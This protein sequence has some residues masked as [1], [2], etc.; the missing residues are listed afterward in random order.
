MTGLS[1]FG[2]LYLYGMHGV[3][4]EVVFW[5]VWM[6]VATGDTALH[7]CSHV[8][9]FLIY[10]VF[11]WM[12]DLLS[13]QLEVYPMVLRGGLYMILIYVWEFVTGKILK[14]TFGCPWDYSEYSTYHVDGLVNF[15]YAPFWLIGSLLA[16]KYLIKNV[17]KLVW[18]DRDQ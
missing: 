1:T 13:D 4:V 12:I 5:A 9:A 2:R 18:I 3:V 14:V 6:L 16:E 11:L 17:R 7:G 15:E 10:S 8:W